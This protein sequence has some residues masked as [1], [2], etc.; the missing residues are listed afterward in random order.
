MRTWKKIEETK[1]RTKD[2]VELKQKNYVRSNKNS[3]QHKN[4]EKLLVKK[5]KLNFEHSKKRI[6]DK[7]QL[8]AAIIEM[9]KQ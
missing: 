9:K 7:K 2:I 8:D 6:E 4:H 3:S 1:S 5:Q